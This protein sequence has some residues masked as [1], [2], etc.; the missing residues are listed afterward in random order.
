MKNAEDRET[1]Q[2][3]STLYWEWIERDSRIR[4]KG[5]ARNL[6]RFFTVYRLRRAGGAAEMEFDI[7]RREIELLVGNETERTTGVP[8]SEAGDTFRRKINMFSFCF[9]W[10]ER[11]WEKQEGSMWLPLTGKRIHVIQGIAD[12]MRPVSGGVGMILSTWLEGGTGE[13]GRTGLGGQNRCGYR[14]AVLA[15]C[16]VWGHWGISC[17]MT[18]LIWIVSLVIWEMTELELERF[19]ER[20]EC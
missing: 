4:G 2:V 19:G 9:L 15:A 17:Q 11:K 6:V 18:F 13:S 1:A 8:L 3:L 20:G 14:D 7:F 5:G 10:F 16:G 12:V